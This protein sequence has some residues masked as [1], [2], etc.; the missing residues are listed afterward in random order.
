MAAARKASGGS[1]GGASNGA[2]AGDGAAGGSVSRETSAGSA[3]SSAAASPASS[4]AG[5]GAAK[6]GQQRASNGA[7]EGAAASAVAGSAAAAGAPAAQQLRPVARAP[8]GRPKFAWG[9]LQQQVWRWATVCLCR[10]AFQKRVQRISCLS[11]A[12]NDAEAADEKRYSWQHLSADFSDV[13]G[14]LCSRWA[15]RRQTASHGIL[16]RGRTQPSMRSRCRS[17]LASLQWGQRRHSLS[18]SSGTRRAARPARNPPSGSSRNECSEAA[19]QCRSG[20]QPDGDAGG[21][22]HAAVVVHRAP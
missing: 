20:L 3:A 9:T 14:V 15:T 16:L 2:P 17:A 22:S 21:R 18:N 12:Q 8:D 7:D 19:Q 6:A 11:K 4:E 13:P 5:K 1:I 10:A